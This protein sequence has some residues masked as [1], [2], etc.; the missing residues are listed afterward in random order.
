MAAARYFI[1][2]VDRTLHLIMDWCVRVW[3][4]VCLFFCCSCCEM[5]S[6]RLIGAMRKKKNARKTYIC[7][8]ASD[9][10]RSKLK[11]T[12]K[13][14]KKQMKKGTEHLLHFDV[15]QKHH[16]SSLSLDCVNMLIYPIGYS[17]RCTCRSE[18]RAKTP[19]MSVILD[20][21][22]FVFFFFSSFS[23]H[24]TNEQKK[25]EEKKNKQTIPPTSPNSFSLNWNLSVFIHYVSR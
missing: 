4:S 13:Q 24:S 18:P 1:S 8:F 22:S 21:F 6:I 3:V 25:G 20:A 2:S 23:R 9:T 17:Y 12:Q 19:L 10:I 7:P 5:T 15:Q 16:H 14:L 11:S